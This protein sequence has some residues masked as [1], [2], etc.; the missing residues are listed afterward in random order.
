MI[1]VSIILKP[2]VFEEIYLDITPKEL[3]EKLRSFSFEEFF[4][5][6]YKDKSYHKAHIVRLDN[7]KTKPCDIFECKQE[8]KSRKISAL[9]FIQ[10]RDRIENHLWRVYLRTFETIQKVILMPPD[11][12]KNSFDTLKK[13]G[14]YEFIP[15][16]T[17]ETNYLYGK[18][19]FTYG[20]QKEKK[21]INY[22][23]NSCKK[24]QLYFGNPTNEL[25][26]HSYLILVKRD[27][28]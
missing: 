18:L 4:K 15:P 20:F 26:Y 10:M 14:F 24:I 6:R 21:V 19:W 22:G 13:I 8:I 3:K 25:Q 9:D 11:F 7:I 12:K 17:N 23:H 2:E 16:H 27:W 1:L 5:K 28:E